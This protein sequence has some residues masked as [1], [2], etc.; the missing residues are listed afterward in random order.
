MILKLLYN[1]KHKHDRSIVDNFFNIFKKT[2]WKLI[3]KLN[4]HVK[5]VLTVFI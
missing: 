4:L 1:K 2:F 5:F 3:K